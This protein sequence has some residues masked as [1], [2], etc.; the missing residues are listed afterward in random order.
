VKSSLTA[1]RWFRTVAAIFFVF[2]WGSAFIP[3]KIGVLASSPLWF[4]V[5]RFGV[6]GAVVLAIAVGLGSPWPQNGKAWT[7][8]ILL[9]VLT[10]ALYLGAT[11]EALRHLSAGVG[12]VVVSTTPLILSL[13][14]PAFLH[15][16]L[17]KK[18][19]AGL[20][21]GFAGVVWIMIAR[22]GTGTAEPRDVLLCLLGVLASVA[23]TIVFKRF[24]VALDVRMTTALQLLSAAIVLVPFAAVLEGA[25]HAV[26]G[27]PLVASF[28][29]LVLVM[30]V[31]ASL[32]WFWLLEQGEA[33]RVTAYYFLSPVFGLLTASFFGE[34]LSIRD[35]GGL[36][37]IA[38]GIAI[39]QRA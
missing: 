33:S 32:L 34:P 17:T 1:T 19:G 31:G 22:T 8:I 24:L 4:L 23:S 16:P 30:S 14:A 26:W 6:S 5:L 18:K 35:L 15:E 12:S 2:L 3:S 37:A 9:G 29:Y 38:L 28:V 25:P 36:I 27:V 39:V 21:L 10:N 11:Y 20:L 13:L 7:L